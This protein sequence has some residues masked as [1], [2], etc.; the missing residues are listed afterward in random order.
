MQM[1]RVLFLAAVAG[2]SGLAAPARAQTT[3]QTNTF[4][5]TNVGGFVTFGPNVIC[6]N[7]TKGTASGFG[8]IFASD[9]ITH[10]P[11]TQPSSNNGAFIE[12]DSYSD[13]CGNSLGFALGGLSGGYVAPNPSLQSAALSGTTTVQDLDFGTQATVTLNLTY[14]GQGPLLVSSGASVSHQVGP[15]TVLVNHGAFKSREATVSGTV[16]INGA[17]PDVSFSTTTLVDNSSGSVTVQKN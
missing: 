12:I 17:R 16:I 5:G 8:F 1:S 6:P 9:S 4:R 2:L 15:Y 3:V 11:G 13:S 7:G 10:S 14:T